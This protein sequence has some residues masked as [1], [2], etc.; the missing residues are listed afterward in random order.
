[1]EEDIM[2]YKETMEMAGATVHSFREFGSYQ[3]DWLA[4]VTWKGELGFVRGSYGSCSG[5]DAYQSECDGLGH[6][7]GEE[8]YHNPSWG[9]CVEGCEKCEQGKRTLAGFGRRYLNS[10]MP[11]KGIIKELEEGMEWDYD[12]TETLEKLRFVD[13]DYIIASKVEEVEEV[14]EVESTMIIEG[15]PV[16]CSED[17]GCAK[18]AS[19]YGSLFDE[20]VFVKIQS[21]SDAKNHPFLDALE[22]KNVRVTIEVDND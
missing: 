10:M 13:P 15:K 22:G 1:M 11:A 2:G 14:E 16:V 3:G 4:K 19:V 7:V 12:K 17:S 21:W 5:C 6:A 18:I 9:D 20:G 8:G